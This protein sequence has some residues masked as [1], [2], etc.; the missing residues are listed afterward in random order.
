MNGIKHQLSLD[1]LAEIRAND[2]VIKNIG[3]RHFVSRSKGVG[4]A[5]RRWKEV[6]LLRFTNGW[7]QPQNIKL[8]CVASDMDRKDGDDL[9]WYIRENC[10]PDAGGH[11]GIF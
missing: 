8:D 1:E 11:R 9:L 3:Y 10:G 7:H 4:R 5:R 2:P 6:E